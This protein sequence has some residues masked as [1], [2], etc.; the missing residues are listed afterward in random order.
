MLSCEAHDMSCDVAL[1]PLLKLMGSETTFSLSLRKQNREAVCP[2]VKMSA[3][4]SKVEMYITWM[5][6]PV[7][8]SQIKMNINLNMFDPCLEDGIGS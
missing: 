2:L 5:S 4:W 7:T 1:T 3:I 6:L 8:F